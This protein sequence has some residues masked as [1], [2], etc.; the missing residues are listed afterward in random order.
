MATGNAVAYL[1]VNKMTNQ[2]K[3]KMFSNIVS[4]ARA[5]VKKT[6]GVYIL[7]KRDYGFMCRKEISFENEKLQEEGKI[8]LVGFYNKISKQSVI[9]DLKFELDLQLKS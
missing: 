1:K 7:Y 9:E 3:S 4:T 2:N 6:K 5:T 8:S